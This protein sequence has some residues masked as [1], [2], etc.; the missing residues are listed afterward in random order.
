M[1]TWT[2]VTPEVVLV[3]SADTVDQAIYLLST[4]GIPG[5]QRH[6]LIP[7]PTRHRYYRILRDERTVKPESPKI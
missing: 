6:Q 2:L 4:G 5:I 1:K 3:I 7:L